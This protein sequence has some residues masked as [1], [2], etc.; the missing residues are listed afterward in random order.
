MAHPGCLL[1]SPANLAHGLQAAERWR[2][3]PPLR[4]RLN[5][6]SEQVYGVPLAN[7]APEPS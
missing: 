6:L 3:D 5:A 4:A 7:P 1:L 2:E